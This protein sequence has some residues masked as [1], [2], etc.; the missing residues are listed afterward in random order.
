MV[1][2]VP[3]FAMLSRT[4]ATLHA[5]ESALG[6]AHPHLHRDTNSFFDLQEFRD[7]NNP[8]EARHAPKLRKQTPKDLA[9]LHI[10]KTHR[11]LLVG[12][13]SNR[14]L[15][16]QLELSLPL[17]KSITTCSSTCVCVCGAKF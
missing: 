5:L 2:F 7:A 12:I 13:H 17:E 15:I 3:S 1:D 6:H 8:N 9:L 4:F 11:D 14:D 16:S 10:I